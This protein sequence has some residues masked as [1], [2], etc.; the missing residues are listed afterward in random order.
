MKT[1]LP[2]PPEI[3]P[4]P[5]KIAPAFKGDGWWTI[6]EAAE[7]FDIDGKKLCGLIQ[8]NAWGDPLG[9]VFSNQVYPFSVERYL[10]VRK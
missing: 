3:T 7:F 5:G 1:P 8:R 9:N 2:Q 6:Q 4:R 10:N